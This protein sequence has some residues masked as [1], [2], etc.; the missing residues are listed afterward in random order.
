MK[1]KRK[2]IPR[3]RWGRVSAVVSAVLGAVILLWQVGLPRPIS[4]NVDFWED[5][6]IYDLDWHP[7]SHQVV[8]SG[9]K[10]YALDWRASNI[11]VYVGKV[12]YGK[13]SSDGGKLAM[14]GGQVWL[15]DGESK[16]QL[17]DFAR[18]RVYWDV[19]W[20]EDDSCFIVSSCGLTDEDNKLLIWNPETY[21]LEGEI[22]G[23][24]ILDEDGGSDFRCFL[25]IERIPNT[26]IVVAESS[27]NIE[28]FFDID[29]R[30]SIPLVSTPVSSTAIIKPSHSGD[31]LAIEYEDENH[32]SI[33]LV[34]DGEEVKRIDT[35]MNVDVLEWNATDELLF[36]ASFD[37]SEFTVWQ[38]EDGEK[39]LN[40]VTSDT[41]YIK[42]H[43]HPHNNYIVLASDKYVWLWDMATEEKWLVHNGYAWLIE[44]SPDGK[45]LAVTSREGLYIYSGFDQIAEIEF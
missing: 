33:V 27:I 25:D 21:E 38:V 22:Q 26:N 23:D 16:V 39:I 24:A 18:Y 20:C 14:A 41:R 32:I 40:D 43:W 28:R 2:R 6:R 29:D 35:T 9:D 19:E 10:I 8:V 42:A 11:S 5:E 1:T 7:D 4:L 31:Y 15:W 37:T 45:K 12:S 44:W 30:M 36:G 34:S 3:L 17:A 13:W